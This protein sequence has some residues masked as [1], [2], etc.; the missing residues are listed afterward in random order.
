MFNRVRKH[1]KCTYCTT[2]HIQFTYESTFVKCRFKGNTSETTFRSQ[3]QMVF[4]APR[5]G[6]ISSYSC[7]FN[8]V[9]SRIDSSKRS[10]QKGFL[11][12]QYISPPSKWPVFGVRKPKRNR[13]KG[14]KTQQND[15]K[16]MPKRCRNDAKTMPKWCQNDAKTILK[17]PWI[18]T[19]KN[20]PKMPHIAPAHIGSKMALKWTKKVKSGQKKR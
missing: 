11:Q 18:D 3:C 15:P 5:T 10:N 16:M 8:L 7:L 1:P 13:L 9:P 19:Q 6:H 20:G 2:G 17:W 14:S 12:S 4:L